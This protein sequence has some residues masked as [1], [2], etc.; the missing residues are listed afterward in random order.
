MASSYIHQHDMG[1]HLITATLVSPLGLHRY[2]RG[3]SHYHWGQGFCFPRGLHFY[4]PGPGLVWASCHYAC[5]VSSDIYNT[6]ESGDSPLT[7]LQSGGGA[8]TRKPAAGGGL[9]AALR[10]CWGGERRQQCF[11]SVFCG[12]GRVMVVE[13]FPV[14]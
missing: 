10:L 6:T 12:Q 14:L 5:V 7:S 9:G 4:P 1:E 8:A 2:P 13:K 3:R 11:H